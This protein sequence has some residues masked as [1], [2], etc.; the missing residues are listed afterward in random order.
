MPKNE[1]IA[2]SIVIEEFA[3]QLV[4]TAKGKGNAP[5]ECSGQKVVGNKV[6]YGHTFFSF[7]RQRACSKFLRRIAWLR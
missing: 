4:K 2:G 1:V 5:T 3:E 7:L 6:I